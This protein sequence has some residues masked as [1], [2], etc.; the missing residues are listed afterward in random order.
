MFLFHSRI[1]NFQIIRQPENVDDVGAAGV[2]F[3]G[4]TAWS[5]FYLSGLAGGLFGAFTSRGMY[6]LNQMRDYFVRFRPN[7]SIIYEFKTFQEV[8]REHAFVF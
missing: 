5:S 6:L 3:A 1:S 2:M 7:Q 8:E 4:L